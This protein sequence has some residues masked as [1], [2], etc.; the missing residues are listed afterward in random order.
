MAAGGCFFQ[1]SSTAK[2][3]YIY[4]QYAGL[5][6]HAGNSG[7]RDKLRNNCRP[8]LSKVNTVV[9]TTTHAKNSAFTISV[10]QDTQTASSMRVRR[11]GE[12]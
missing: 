11:R 1:P 6:L 2:T 9:P 8:A 3:N 12:L 7:C 5:Q 4:R 10:S